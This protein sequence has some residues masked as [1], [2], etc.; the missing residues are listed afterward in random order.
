MT[1]YL[2]DP[3]L[4]NSLRMIGKNGPGY[5]KKLT[6]G[7]AISRFLDTNPEI[8]KTNLQ[9]E[10]GDKVYKWETQVY[11]FKEK[12]KLVC[13]IDA[14]A[15][16]GYEYDIHE[17]DPAYVTWKQSKKIVSIAER[18][19]KKVIQTRERLDYWEVG[20]MK[21]PRTKTKII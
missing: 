15:L 9:Y 1:R 5:I 12:D 21:Q 16:H 2:N 13:V 20:L 10:M 11:Y 6:S 18:F 19:G 8:G 14:H 17:V 4:T 3:E 7:T